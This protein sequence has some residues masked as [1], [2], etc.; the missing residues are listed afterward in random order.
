MKGRQTRGSV[1]LKH[2]RETQD[3]RRTQHRL[4][5]DLGAKSVFTISKWERGIQVPTVA[6]ALAIE[7][8]TAGAVPVAWWAAEVAEETSANEAA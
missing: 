1:G 3:P 6:E 4:A 7:E 8:Y 2:W 5:I